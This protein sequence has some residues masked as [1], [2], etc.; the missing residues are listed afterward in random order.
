MGFSAKFKL[1][2][3]TKNTYRYEESDSPEGLEKI[4]V[5]YIQKHAFGTQPPGQ[6][7][8]TVKEA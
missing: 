3:E 7:E 2:R 6:I 5:I 1:A 4:R 8:L